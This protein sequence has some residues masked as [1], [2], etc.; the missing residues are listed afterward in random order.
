MSTSL[1]EEDFESVETDATFEVS[2]TFPDFTTFISVKGDKF[3]PWQLFSVYTPVPVEYVVITAVIFQFCCVFLIFNT[4]VFGF[5]RKLN[6]VTRPYILSLVS[7]DLLLGIVTLTSFVV[8]ISSQSIYVAEIA[9][10]VYHISFIFGFGFYLYPSLF[11][12]CER[13]LVVFIA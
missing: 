3:D 9:N 12:A 13:F 8:A 5:Y 7:L 6:E 4:L 2:E 1:F 11:L 10:H